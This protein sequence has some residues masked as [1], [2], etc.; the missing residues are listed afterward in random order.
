MIVQ[1]YNGMSMW[2]EALAR[3]VISSYVVVALPVGG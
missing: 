3:E 1:R 2:V